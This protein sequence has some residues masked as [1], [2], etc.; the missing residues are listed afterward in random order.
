MTECA[1]CMLA[2]QSEGKELPL[3]VQV[4]FAFVIGMASALAAANRAAGVTLCSVC[5]AD[6]ESSFTQLSGQPLNILPIT[7]PN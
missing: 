5:A 7:S 6:L 2:E 3:R 4:A 1:A